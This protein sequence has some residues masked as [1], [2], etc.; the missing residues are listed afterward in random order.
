MDPEPTT[1]EASRYRSSDLVHKVAPRWVYGDSLT[2]LSRRELVSRYGPIG[3]AVDAL[4]GRNSRS[5][6]DSLE[7]DL[8]LKTPKVVVIATATNDIFN[9]PDVTLQMHRARAMLPSTTRLYWINAYMESGTWE[10]DTINPQ[11]TVPGITVIDW[12]GYNLVRQVGGHS[13][14]VDQYGTHVSCDGVYWRDDLIVTSVG[15]R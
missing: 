8:R 1:V 2:Y 14:L 11:F 6:V 13:P 4:W 12:Y 15:L 9:P 10:E 3:V 5:A 7:L